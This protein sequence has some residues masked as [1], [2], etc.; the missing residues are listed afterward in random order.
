MYVAVHMAKLYEVIVS[1]HDYL[2]LFVCRGRLRQAEA[3]ES[4]LERRLGQREFVRVESVPRRLASTKIFLCS[5]FNTMSFGSV[6]DR[7][8]T[9]GQCRNRL[10]LTAV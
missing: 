6:E 8:Y 7:A 9:A 5:F 2:P 4:K 3:V 10:I 1:K